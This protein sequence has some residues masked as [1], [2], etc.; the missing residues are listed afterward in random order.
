[1]Q[2]CEEWWPEQIGAAWG[3]HLPGRL[4]LCNDREYDNAKAGIVG[5]SEVN[6]LGVMAAA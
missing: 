2:R 5:L 3:C 1:M 6:R 4:S